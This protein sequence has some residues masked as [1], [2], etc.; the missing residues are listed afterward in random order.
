[1]AGTVGMDSTERSM[2][3]AF[4]P[5]TLFAGYRVDSLVG[6]GGMGVVYRAT[7]LS[8]QRPVALKLIAPELAEDERFRVRFLRESRLAA[9]LDHPS[10][11]PIYEAG[12][13]D[14]DLYLAMR[15]VE[16]SDL[17]T[18]LEREGRLSPERAL[19]ILAQVAGA[20]DAAHRRALVHRDVK[21]ANVLLDEDG[22]AYLT[23]FGIAKQLGGGSTDSGRIVGTL[24]YLAPEQI[25]G[26]GVDART[27]S[28]A[29]CCA[30]YECLAGAPPFRRPTEAETLWA[31]MRDDPVPIADHPKLDPVLAK[32]LAKDRE[33]RH[34]SCVDLIDAAAG[35]LGLAAPLA[36]RR[37]SRVALL[38]A[39]GG[40]LLGAAAVLALTQR[41]GEGDPGSQGPLLDVATNSVGAVD[42]GTSEL[43]L[44][45]PLPGRPT[46]VVAAGDTA[47][48]ATVDSTSVTGVSA[49]TRSISRTVPLR[50][51]ADAIAA[52]E[53][54]IWV[55]D[56]R[57]GWVS[58]IPAGY[59][60]V[61]RRI[62]VPIADDADRPIGRLQAPS[63]SLAVGGGAVWLSN[64]SASI[65]QID[66]DTGELKATP[67]GRR[68]DAVASAGG[69]VW[70]LSSRSAMLLRV[71]ADTG[72]VT[73]RVPIAARPR[74]E[75]PF[76]VA[77]AA[78]ARNVWVL[79]GNTA[80]VTQIDARTLGV[81]ATIP[82][83]VDRVPTDI[84]AT[85]GTAW[86]SN[87][88][89]SVARIDAGARTASEI[90]VGESL[91]RV[92]AAGATV[93]V[94]TTAFDHKLPGGAG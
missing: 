7:D 13:R 16:G 8:L 56:G 4:I 28:Y 61:T 27:D 55:A 46:D 81:T 86:V 83:G 64:G 5:G 84:A 39:L 79:N 19:G 75:G 48:V 78:S 33:H 1:M 35:A 72:R 21:P 9:S 67:A 43:A 12:E 14:G 42:A 38:L 6:R 25:R 45:A 69:M 37:L 10:V 63:A 58:R 22:H 88:D 77:I 60:R 92:A 57:R 32:G 90:R 93:W 26:D 15:Y 30:L 94:T 23:D 70:A 24:D 76:P 49:R 71:D 68:V 29:L 65:V 91:E 2:K 52:G 34:G 53:G 87:G 47:W 85:A 73:D 82:I 41:L 31:Q 54:S 20:L 74:A 17:K 59:E 44:A 36:G 3:A 66:P 62:R 51:S 89:G 18:L 40:V 11:V 80:T 50:G